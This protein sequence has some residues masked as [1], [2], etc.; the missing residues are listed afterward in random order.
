MPYVLTTIIFIV[1]WI[2]FEVYEIN[3]LKNKNR[4]V[5]FF[6]VSLNVA[7]FFT[8]LREVPQ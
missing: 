8:W 5:V 4:K 1:L 2:E 6:G 3:N 7:Y